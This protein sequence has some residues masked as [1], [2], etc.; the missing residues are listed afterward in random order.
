[1]QKLTGFQQDLTD[2][3]FHPVSRILAQSV[4]PAGTKSAL[5]LKL[6]PE[7]PVIKNAIPRNLID[8]PAGHGAINGHE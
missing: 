3:G 1:M 2:M 6:T 5:Q 8:I 4:G 7:S